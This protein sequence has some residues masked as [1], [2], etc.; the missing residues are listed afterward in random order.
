[1]SFTNSAIQ[2]IIESEVIVLM[3]V[4]ITYDVNTEDVLVGTSAELLIEAALQLN[5]KSFPFKTIII[6]NDSGFY[7][8][9]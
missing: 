2:Y 8:F 3:M 6:K 4:L 9:T 1:M 7:E 5:A